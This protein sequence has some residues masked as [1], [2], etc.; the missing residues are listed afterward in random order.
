M[1]YMHPFTSEIIA[2]GLDSSGLSLTTSTPVYLW[3]KPAA[4]A[5]SQLLGCKHGINWL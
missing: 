4:A 2:H 1:F 3:S 5:D